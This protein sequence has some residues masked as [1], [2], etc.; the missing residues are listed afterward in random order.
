MAIPSI[1]GA[2]FGRAAEDLRKSVADGRLA[3]DELSRRLA[4]DDL[5]LIESTLSPSGW[6]D[7][8]VYGRLLELLK[9]VEGGGRTGYLRERG[10]QSAEV[11]IGAGIYQQ[12]EYLSRV[13]VMQHEDPEAR[14]QAFGRDLRLLTSLHASLLNFGKQTALVDPD[15]PDRYVLELT[16]VAPMPEALCWTTD[17]FVNRMG[18]EH[19]DADMWR[20][21]RPR[22]DLVRYRMARRP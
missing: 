12:M 22:A 20:W 14:F 17:G 19:F 21:E 11:L 4:P 18:R 1:K 13:E 16:D 8:A 5:A 3:H 2:I 7:V 6:Y 9:D 15:L 10:A